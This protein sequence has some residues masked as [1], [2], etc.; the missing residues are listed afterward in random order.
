M[1]EGRARFVAVDYDSDPGRRRAARTATERYNVAGDVHGD[2]AD[3][4]AG[5]AHG[6]VV[7]VGCGAGLLMALL[8]RRGMP[9]VGVDVSAAPL[10]QGTGARVRADAIKLPFADRSFGGVAALY[11]LYHLPD[12][13]Q[14]IAECHR[15]LR[16]GGLFAVCSPSR[17]DDPELVE[18]VPEYA[19]TLDAMSFDS[20]EGPALIE[21]VFGNVEVDRWDGPYTRLPDRDAVE[22]YLYGHGLPRADIASAASRVPTPLTMTKRG[23]IMYAYKQQA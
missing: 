14:A 3:R 18:A 2:V 21:D 5:E 11:V 12:P 4:L 13:V 19:A 16:P 10:Q 20:E 15:V 1:P 8:G 6:P 22:L 17:H 7:D 9:V 23:A